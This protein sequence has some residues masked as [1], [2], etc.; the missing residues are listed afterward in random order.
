MYMQRM[1]EV[2]AS[3]I[4]A[5]SEGLQAAEKGT[6]GRQGGTM[7]FQYQGKEYWLEFRYWQAVNVRFVDCRIFEPKD[8]DSV[9]S[10]AMGGARC[11]PGDKFCKEVGRKVALARAIRSL[12]REVRT[13]IWAAYHGR[14]GAK[15]AA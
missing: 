10:L 6:K 13:S 8:R 2:S 15:A 5:P 11:S 3:R 14:K 4:Y 7:R 9:A 1:P 12:P